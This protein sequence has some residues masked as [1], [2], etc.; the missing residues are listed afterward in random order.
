MPYNTSIWI[1]LAK[2]ED[3]KNA[4]KVLNTACK[5]IP[6]DHT[7]WVH[8]AKLEETEGN[9]EIVPKLLKKA[10]KNLQKNVKIT[11]DQWLKEA[12]EAEISGSLATARALI[13]ETL[14]EGI[15][16]V[17]DMDENKR[18]WLETAENFL[19]RGAIE[20]ARALILATCRNV[21]KDHGVWMKAIKLENEHGTPKTVSNILKQALDACNDTELFYLMYAKHLWKQ[22][23]NI[24]EAIRVLKEG[25]QKLDTEEELYLALVKLYKEKRQYDDARQLLIK[26]RQK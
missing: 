24:D 9:F 1:A 17:T 3:Y 5:K 22:D 23:K 15:D 25:L 26:G 19:D 10:I 21:P 18:I 6:T 4:R 11:K 20:C 16:D 8:A 14:F 13:E 2:L 7:I 12:Y